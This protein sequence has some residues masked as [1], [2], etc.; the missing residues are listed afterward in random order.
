MLLFWVKIKSE[1]F[2]GQPKEPKY[3]LGMLTDQSLSGTLLKESQ[4]MS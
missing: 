1:P 2:H 4:F 3:F